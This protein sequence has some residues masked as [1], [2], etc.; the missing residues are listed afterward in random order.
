LNGHV[1]VLTGCRKGL[2][3]RA[4]HSG[5]ELAAVRELDRLA[6]LFGSENVVIELTDHGDPIDVDRNEALAGLAARRHL[7]TVA[8]NNVHYA[9]PD[10]RRLATA[11]AAVRARRSLDEIDGWLPA[12]GTAHLRDGEEMA[13]W[14]ADY[15]HAVTY[16]ARLAAEI[17]FDLT[18]VAPKLPDYPIPEPGHTE[19]SWLR[20]LTYE[21]ARQRYGSREERPDAYQQLDRELDKIEQLGFPG[22]FLVVYDIV[23]FCRDNN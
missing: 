1:L 7:R 8:T 6:A 17:A 19:M 2:V 11:L 3:P 20:K 10:R 22:Y 21:G 16:A 14:F 18:L 15:P 5:G 4:L 12:A 23:K 13:R 9:T